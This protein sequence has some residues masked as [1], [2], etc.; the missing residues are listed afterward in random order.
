[1]TEKLAPSTPSTR[2]IAERGEAIY[3]EKYRTKFEKTSRGKFVAINI[4]NGDAVLADCAEDALR[5][6]VENDPLGFFHLI[7]VGYQAAFEAGWYMSNA[8]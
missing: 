2:F 3:S 7:R 1:M 8:R 4:V 6:A 5:Q